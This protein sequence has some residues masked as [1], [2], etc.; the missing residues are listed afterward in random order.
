[1]AE[2]LDDLFSLWGVFGAATDDLQD[3]FVDFAAGIH[4]VCSVMA[5][6]CV[7]KDESLRPAF[8]RGAPENQAREQRKRLAGL[9]GVTDANLD[10]AALVTL[11]DEIELRRA[12]TEHFEAQGTRFAAAIHKIAF[13]FGFS[14]KLMIEIVAVVCRDPDFTVPEIYLSAL[15][16][17][18]DEAVL[19]MMNIQVGKFITA[20]FVERF[21]PKEW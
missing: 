13:R 1:M 8:R 20:Y 3:I 21:W 5:H 14:A 16:S 2:A 19:S 17:I 11:L 18:T 12:L 6:L 7:A 9:F 15:E 10:R 4:S